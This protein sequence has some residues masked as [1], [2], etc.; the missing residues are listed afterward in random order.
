MAPDDQ[1]LYGRSEEYGDDQDSRKD[2]VSL[3][4]DAAADPNTDK[5]R[6]SM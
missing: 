5:R 3:A 4:R 1:G 6:R 2:G